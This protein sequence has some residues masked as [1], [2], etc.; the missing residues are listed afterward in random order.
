MI[1]SAKCF[2]YIFLYFPF[3][4]VAR[5][6]QWGRQPRAILTRGTKLRMRLWLL[7]LEIE[8]T[9][10]FSIICRL[11]HYINHANLKMMIFYLNI[12]LSKW[13]SNYWFSPFQRLLWFLYHWEIYL[14][15]NI[16]ELTKKRMYP[17]PFHLIVHDLL[18][19]LWSS[20]AY[21]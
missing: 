19:A 15:Q 9:F 3:N 21:I 18:G 10:S 14:S 1:S 4:S 17:F 20:F 6:R 8:I 5:V 13:E 12:F 16:K 2:E 7:I 11:Y